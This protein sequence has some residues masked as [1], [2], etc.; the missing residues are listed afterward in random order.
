MWVNEFRSVSGFILKS[1]TLSVSSWFQMFTRWFPVC[2]Y[3]G[4]SLGARST[5]VLPPAD[6]IDDAI[7]RVRKIFEIQKVSM[8]NADLEPVEKNVC[9]GFSF[10]S[11]SKSLSAKCLLKLNF[12]RQTH[13]TTSVRVRASP[14]DT[15]L[16]NENK[17]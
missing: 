13:K 16:Y 2:R 3:G 11:L 12:V 14:A 10:Y 6:E 7:E 4:F 15:N 8:R 5:Q 17:P 9:L 1:G